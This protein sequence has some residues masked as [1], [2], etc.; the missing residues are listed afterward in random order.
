M[1]VS[2]HALAARQLLIITSCQL[3]GPRV[4]SRNLAYR[5]LNGATCSRFVE[6]KLMILIRKIFDGLYQDR[7]SGVPLWYY[8]SKASNSNWNLLTDRSKFFQNYFY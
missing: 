3:P 8:S 4:S 7:I 6:P 2:L 5:Q 1:L